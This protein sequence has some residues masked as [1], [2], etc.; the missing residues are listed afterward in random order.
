MAKGL[1]QSQVY[2]DLVF[3]ADAKQARQEL[4]QLQQQ[5]LNLTSP[6]KNTLGLKINGIEDF[7]KAGQ[8]IAELTTTL[9]LA[10][11]KMGNL[12]LTKLSQSLK[13]NNTN[14]TSY[15]KTLSRLGPEGEQAFVQLARGVN[16]AG[17]SMKKSYGILTEFKN[18]LMN[19]ARW[20]ISS[21]ILHGFMGAVQ[22]AYGYAQDLNKSLNNIRIV[23]GQNIDQM[24]R[25]ADQ[26][27]KAAKALSTT[28]T[29]YT[30]ASLIYYQQGLSDSE[31]K[32]RT[33]I[34]IKMANAAGQ[35]A[36]IVS[37]QMTAVWN[38]FD[39]G[40][41]SLEYYADVMTALGAATASSTDEIAAGLEKFSAVAGTVGLSYEYATSALATVTAETRQSADVVGTAFKTLFA[42]I[43]GLKLGE[44][45][46]DGTDLNKYSQALATVGVQI[47]D[48]SGEMRAMDDILNDLG[49]RWQTLAKDEQIALAQTVAGVRQYNQLI[50]LMDNWD[51]FQ[52]NLETA[53]TSEGSLQAQADIYAESWEAARDRVTASMETIYQQLLNDKFFIAITDGFGKFLDTLSNVID[54]LGG[55]PGV[56]SLVSGLLFKIFGNNMANAMSTFAFN[57]RSQKKSFEEMMA[58]RKDANKGVRTMLGDSTSEADQSQNTALNLEFDLYDKIIEK[59]RHLKSLGIEITD[60]EQKLLDVLMKQQEEYTESAIASG[61]RV[62]EAALL[63]NQKQNKI[64]QRILQESNKSPDIQQKYGQTRSQ[65]EIG[66]LRESTRSVGVMK[67]MRDNIGGM[68]NITDMEKYLKLINTSLKNNTAEG[69]KFTKTLKRI[70]SGELKTAAEILTAMDEE[71]AEATQDMGK[72]DAAIRKGLERIKIVGP[73]ADK[74]I[75]EM[76]QSFYGE[77]QETFGMV[78]DLA[79]A[80][81]KAEQTKGVIDGIKG[82]PPTAAQGFTVLAQGISNVAMVASSVYGL[83]QTW[84]NEDMSFG[85]K[86]ISTFTTLGM[87]I[88]MVT[89]AFNKNSLAQLSALSA[90]IANALGQKGVTLAYNAETGAIV[91][92]TGATIGFGAALWTVL[93]PIGLVMAA[94]AGL[95]VVAKLVSDAI[96]ADAIAAEKAAETAQELGQAYEDAKNKHQELMD[97][98]TNYKEA[99]KA[100]DVLV[101]GT[102]EYQEALQ[103]ANQAAIEL[104]QNNPGKFVKGVD[105]DWEDGKLE[106]S[107]GSLEKVQQASLDQ[108]NRLYAA[109]QM[110]NAYKASTAAIV[111]INDANDEVESDR[112]VSEGWE[113]LANIGSASSGG[114]NTVS[115]A[116]ERAEISKAAEILRTT[117]TVGV[118]TDKSAMEKAL[119]VEGLEHLTDA[120]WDNHASLEAATEAYN[121][122]TEAYENAAGIIVSS[123]INGD[124]A[125]AGSENK[126]VVQEKMSKEYEEQYKAEMQKLEDDAWGKDGI[127]KATGVNNEAQEIF[128]E[129]AKAAGLTGA[130]L[131]DTT[132]SDDN[133]VFK[134]DDGTGEMKEVSLEAMKTVVASSRATDSITGTASKL[135][136]VLDTLDQAIEETKNAEP[137]SVNKNQ[138]LL[139]E[140]VKAGFTEDFSN[141]TQ[142]ELE[143][144]GQLTEEQLTNMLITM[145][146]EEYETKLQELGYSNAQEYI[147]AFTNEVTEQQENLKENLAVFEGQSLSKYAQNAD[148]GSVNNL[149][150]QIERSN[151][152]TPEGHASYGAALSSNINSMI[153]TIDTNK[154]QEAFEVL[155]NIDWSKAG[156]TEE[157]VNNLGKLGIASDE[158]TKKI[159][160]LTSQMREL[161][162]ADLNDLNTALDTD[163]DEEEYVDLANYIQDIADETEDF[164]DE[165]QYNEKAAKKNAEAILRFNSAIEDI[166]ENYEDW[167]Y[168]LKQ[169]SV[170]DQ[171]KAVKQM[172]NAY[173]DLLDIDM[174][175]LSDDFIKNEENLELMKQAAEGSEEAYQKLQEA[176]GKDILAQIGIDTSQYETDLA[177]L[178][179]LA[180]QTEGMGLADIEA[181]AS[182]DD[183]EFLNTLTNMVN[184]AGMTAQEATDY[185]ASM[186]IDAE[187]V[188][189]TQTAT[190]TQQI[191]TIDPHIEW[192]PH[193]FNLPEFMGGPVA[194]NLPK[195]KLMANAPTPVDSEKNMTAMGLKVSSATKSSGGNIKHKHSTS[196]GGKSGSNGPKS[197]GGGG[198]SSKPSKTKQTKKSDIVERYKEI[199]DA[200]DDVS[201]A[202]DKASKKADRL[203]GSAK[204]KAMQ[205]EIAL[206]K[207]KVTLLEKQIKE[208]EALLEIDKKSLDIA[209][210][211]L[212]LRFTY[213]GLGNITNYTQQLNEL[214]DQLAEVEDTMNSMSTKE[215]QDEYKESTYEP[216]QEK[217]SALE[218]AMDQYEETRELIEDLRTEIDDE[219]Q[220]QIDKEFEIFKYKIEVKLDVNDREM[221]I[222]DLLLKRIDD[223]AFAAA[224]SMALLTS[225]TDEMLENFSIYEQ[226]INDIY[227]K[228][229]LTPEAAANMTAEQLEAVGLSEAEIETLQEYND[230]LIETT[231]NLMDI[232]EQI[233]QSLIDLFDAW[234]DEINE[235][236]DK[237]SLLNDTLSAFQNIVDVLGYNRLG[238]SL[239]WQKDMI[240]A[241]NTVGLEQLESLVEKK[242]ALEETAK[243][244]QEHLEAAQKRLEKAQKTVKDENVLA[245]LEA[246][247]KYWEEMVDKTQNELDQATVDVYTSLDEFV[248]QA[249]ENYKRLTEAILEE[250]ERS[251]S[252]MGKTLEETM[253]M[254]DKAAELEERYVSNYEKA[255]SLSKLTS[256]IEKSLNDTTSLKHQQQL[257]DMLK[258]IQE[259][260]ESG[261]ELSQYDLDYLQK[262]YDLTVAQMSLE[263]AYNAKTQ[264]IRRRDSE[265]NWGYVYTA[266]EE[267][268]EAAMTTYRD[269]VYE[270]ME[271]N[272]NFIRDTE[273]KLL[274]A[275][276]RMAEELAAL[277][278]MALTE[279]EYNERATAIIEHY[280]ELDSYY[281]GEIQKALDNNNTLYDSDA[282]AFAEKAGFKLSTAIAFKND[283]ITITEEM[284]KTILSIEEST[285]KTRE[286]Y[287]Q[288]LAKATGLSVNTVT[289]LYKDGVI[290]ALELS[291]EQ[292]DGIASIDEQNFKNKEDYLKEI[293][294]ITGLSIDEVT[295]MYEAGTLAAI[296]ETEKLEGSVLGSNTVMTLSFGQTT[297]SVVTGYGTAAA[298]GAA[299]GAANTVLTAGLSANYA[300]FAAVTEAALGIAGM[301]SETF[302]AV[303]KRVMETSKEKANQYK[304]S[305]RQLGEQMKTSF[306]EGANAVT[307]FQKQY[308]AK[309]GECVTIT[310]A[311]SKAITDLMKKLNKLDPKIDSSFGIGD[312]TNINNVSDAINAWKN[313]I[314]SS[315]SLGALIGAEI[316]MD[317]N[318]NWGNGQE[319][320]NKMKELLGDN[321]ED[322]WKAQVDYSNKYSYSGQTYSEWF[323]KWKQELTPYSYNNMKSYDT[324]GY[325]GA[326][327]PDGKL[328]MLHE[329]ELVLNKQDTSNFL[330]ALDVLERIISN[331]SANS[332][333]FNPVQPIN[334]GNL[335]GLQGLEQNITIHADFPDATSAKDIEEAFNLMINRASQYANIK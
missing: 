105:Y 168:T 147:T 290:K 258:E 198:S 114:T 130:T 265:G 96:N 245:E 190:D 273:S 260:Q 310:K 270:M 150:N 328:A 17:A 243:T 242:E 129:Y 42:R 257:K 286:E 79:L 86:L 311:L 185:L 112:Y 167:N 282:L 27:N 191:R 9:D 210:Q 76:R 220:S 103:K 113:A 250:W 54:T 31:V 170:Q 127:S 177:K 52:D 26:A 118:Y 60:E 23:T 269:K 246:D 298:A 225:K 2:V 287:L 331:V 122:G 59:K 204:V 278:D 228:H 107:E 121:Q 136:N 63:S 296:A 224:Q 233:E 315:T 149:A 276:Q 333:T 284:A 267:D 230:G 288:A 173:A 24:S 84:N 78:Q 277:A 56:L 57:L 197:S 160:S 334:V 165:L 126:D 98:I 186:G 25:F 106:F 156:A 74:I 33:D 272:E 99:E 332:L 295:E 81:E 174:D 248:T 256:S 231:E 155:A 49:T 152:L 268:K 300:T 80:E 153:E 205:E 94:I 7:A 202:M 218:A 67:S 43:E 244:S 235:T 97:S 309:I 53:Y 303:S 187:V 38:N 318:S 176:A 166:N 201:D 141:F 110:G 184:Q 69:E 87:V 30:N 281:L 239:D 13:S 222:L 65:E 279:E 317:P 162:G 34:T 182:L 180:Q 82:P 314:I 249:V 44:T 137:G 62:D 142:V 45:L 227:A 72:F 212:G 146:G 22:K 64:L 83:F 37:D 20:Q 221:K 280:Q 28:T 47:K 223:D 335:S 312:S 325:T 93:W 75:E 215:A 58:L 104:I 196:G 171:A 15:A 297:L 135:T 10:K 323:D 241:Q 92:S 18:T 85:E 326:W 8:K 46:E 322:V 214:Y 134:Y 306:S 289:K 32:E 302:G 161:A 172:R 159:M 329:K 5:M 189:D 40:S 164:S 274:E 48:A 145:F 247:V 19:T 132:G 262:K 119:K 259:I 139:L 229:G 232:K 115:Y 61:K 327:G 77:G 51:T 91:T 148:A 95:V 283:Y 66:G 102:K 208:A 219:V 217:I 264:V 16:Q 199:T 120:M 11:D 41:K 206:S 320:I 140:G 116:A 125:M 68:A 301:S 163:V 100:L 255:Y 154:Q 293:A 226:G 330:L 88:P 181:G 108:T 263:D 304:E 39:N 216:L 211:N 123:I 50:S 55:L 213:D 240:E 294:K 14:L 324:G 307:G 128:N 254:Y 195:F 253:N 194:V 238:L 29:E 70:Q 305:V 71:I 209:A 203:Y 21:S 291:E 4:Q 12:D 237:F 188:T 316:W 308:S 200:I 266:N 131:S 151:E 178:N 158:T 275:R 313:G 169:G 138:E 73:E 36:E 251:I 175:S 179:A 285:F 6:G 143:N 3:Q 35:S 90:G 133:R 234:N 117:D 236:I 124:S 292:R 299:F 101:E 261:K 193:T 271:L 89:T 321:W 252:A 319:R 111:S 157:A 192:E 1:N 207:K 109:Q 144:L 183:T